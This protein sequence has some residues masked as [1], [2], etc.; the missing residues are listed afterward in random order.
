MAN[1]CKDLPDE[2]WEL[3]LNRLLLRHPSHLE[4]LS[5]SYKRFLSITNTLRT[6][7]EITLGHALIELDLPWTILFSASLLLPHFVGFGGKETLV[8]FSVRL[9]LL[10]VLITL[11][12]EE[13]RACL[14]SWR[15]VERNDA[16]RLLAM[17]WRVST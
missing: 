16:N 6:H 1:G 12:E 17:K 13:V 3:I 8:S 5:L 7:L 2:F 14:A 10:R 15:R 4:S 9:G 11:I